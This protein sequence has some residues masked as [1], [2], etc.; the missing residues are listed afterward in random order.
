MPRQ[1]LLSHKNLNKL[2]SSCVC[3]RLLVLPPPPPQ[4]I[5]SPT[6]A[7]QISEEP[8]SPTSSPLFSVHDPPHRMPDAASSTAAAGRSSTSAPPGPALPAL[9]RPRLKKS[10]TIAGTDAAAV[11]AAAV[12]GLSTTPAS[13]SSSVSPPPPHRAFADFASDPAGGGGIG[14]RDWYYPS[15]LGAGPHASRARGGAKA[16]L[17]PKPGPPPLPPRQPRTPPRSESVNH[18][19]QSSPPEAAVD[20]P[21]AATAST[22]LVA[23]KRK[24]EQKVE[25][26][27]T[28]SAGTPPQ[29]I[30]K[31]K[32]RFDGSFAPLVV[33]VLL[34][35]LLNIPVLSFTG[36]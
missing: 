3:F 22:R 15:F 28:T 11:A 8:L 7:T 25:I 17:P 18:T 36:L 27:R 9:T 26:A 32:G 6:F 4:L 23:E 20:G 13:S 30:G 21:S 14:D 24:L 10:R 33:N 12:R 16:A 5:I 1:Q 2:T 19:A 31:K 35:R 29:A 34:Y